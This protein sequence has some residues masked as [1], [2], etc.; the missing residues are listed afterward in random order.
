MKRFQYFNIFFVLKLPPIPSFIANVYIPFLSVEGHVMY[1]SH[2]LL[3][4][5]GQRYQLTY[6][7]PQT[8]SKW[9][10]ES[11][12]REFSHMLKY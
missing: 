7:K 10:I 11:S 4:F 2:D 9:K 8:L 3:D 1:S 5:S 12:Q 6:W